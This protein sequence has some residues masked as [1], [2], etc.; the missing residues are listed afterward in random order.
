MQDI[1]H[2]SGAMSILTSSNFEIWHKRLGY[3]NGKGHCELNKQGLISGVGNMS[4]GIS[5]HCIYGKK[6]KVKFDTKKHT[7]KHILEYIHADL[8]DHHQYPH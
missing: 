7:T 8:W 5:E 3:M 6:T 4:L 1:I 2:N